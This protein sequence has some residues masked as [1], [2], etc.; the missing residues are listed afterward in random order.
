MGVDWVN[1]VQRT[2]AGHLPDPHDPVPCDSGIDVYFTEMRYGGASFAIIEDR[3]FKSGPGDTLS[4]SQRAEGRRDP[5]VVDVEGAE[6]LGPRQE[7]FLNRWAQ[8]S[9]GSDFRLVCSQTIF[10]KATT[11]S[12]G[13]LERRLTDLD[14]GGWPQAGRNRA[15]SAL[16]PVQDV[17]ML[18]GD[19]HVGSLV[20]HGIDEWEDGASWCPE[21]RMGS[22]GRGGPSSRARIAYQ[23]LQN[24]QGATATGSGT[25]LRFWP[26]PTRSEEAT[27]T[28][29]SGG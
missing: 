10:C 9:G 23:T 4:P 3:K 1:A 24:G 27:P 7:A 11:H 19:Q 28:K 25:G 21:L 5:R 18:H 15:L 17:I 6:L 14:C 8:A 22:P 29:G 2:Q 26:R 16:R 20:R 12:G 13:R